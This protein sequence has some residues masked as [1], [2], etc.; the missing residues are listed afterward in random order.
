VADIEAIGA[1]DLDDVLK[2]S[3]S[4]SS[5]ALRLDPIY[6]IRGIH[7]LFNPQVLVLI[8]GI[9][10]TNLFVGSDLIWGGMPIN[11][12]ARIEVIRG[13]GSA[14]YGADAFAGVIN[15]IT[16]TAQDIDGTEIGARAEI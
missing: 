2:P 11:D 14:V 12:I 5:N 6:V 7:S 13:P 3:D 4:M 16:K 8:N 1:T 15:I 10:I 9:P